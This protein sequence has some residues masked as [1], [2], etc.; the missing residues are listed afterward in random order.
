MQRKLPAEESR[1]SLLL[2]Q[3]LRITSFHFVAAV[4]GSANWCRRPLESDEMTDFFKSILNDAS[5]RSLL[6]GVWKKRAS[7]FYHC[8]FF[9]SSSSSFL[10]LFLLLLLLRKFLTFCEVCPFS[11]D[12]L[13]ELALRCFQFLCKSVFTRDSLQLAIVS[14]VALRASDRTPEVFNERRCFPKKLGSSANRD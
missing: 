3:S 14:L 4:S 5:Q 2:S 12:F 10:L 9:F 13:L 6:K 11:H 7:R 1:R 8:F